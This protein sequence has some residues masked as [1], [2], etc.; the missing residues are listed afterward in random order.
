MD[1]LQT[2]PEALHRFDHHFGQEDAAIG[3]EE[4]VEGPTDPIIAEEVHLAGFKP[5]GFGSERLNGLLLAVDRFS[6]D[7]DGT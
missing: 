1:L 3:I 4:T 5:K 2:D 6:L 7:D